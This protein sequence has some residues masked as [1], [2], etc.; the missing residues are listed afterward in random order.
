MVNFVP[1]V[2]R[3]LFTCMSKDGDYL[4][5]TNIR[6]FYFK[7]SVVVS[8]GSFDLGLLKFWLR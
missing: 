2:V 8:Y 6:S 7:V 4:Q 3:D 5:N 1:F